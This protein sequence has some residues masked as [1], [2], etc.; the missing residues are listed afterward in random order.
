MPDY[1][2]WV[3][4]EVPPARDA[5]ND[6]NATLSPRELAKQL[7]IERLAYAGPIERLTL[8]HPQGLTG[9]YCR[10]LMNHDHVPWATHGSKG[11]PLKEFRQL[12]DPA[13]EQGRLLALMTP[14]YTAR[15]FTADAGTAESLFLDIVVCNKGNS[16]C[17]FEG[18]YPNERQVRQA[19]P[20]GQ[21]NY[22][23]G[24]CGKE[25]RVRSE[26]PEGTIC[27]YKGPRTQERLVRK[28]RAD[29][30]IE[31][32]RIN[33]QDVAVRHVT[34]DG[35]TITT[36]RLDGKHHGGRTAYIAKVQSGVREVYEGEQNKERLVMRYERDPL[37]NIQTYKGSGNYERLV[38]KDWL[39][40]DADLSCFEP[41][42]LKVSAPPPFLVRRDFFE[43]PRRSERLV[44]LEDWEEGVVTVE[45]HY[46]GSHL[47]P[48]LVFRFNPQT[49][50]AAY[51]TGKHGEEV[52]YKSEDREGNVFFYGPDG[53]VIDTEPA[54]VGPHAKKRNKHKPKRASARATA[55]AEAARRAAVRKRWRSAAWRAL[56]QHRA[57]AEAT[58]ANAEAAARQA[59][60][61]EQADAAEKDASR[62]AAAEAKAARRAAIAR[63]MR[64]YLERARLLRVA[65]AIGGS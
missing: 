23:K 22:Y 4:V 43:G 62:A 20:N 26:H 46:K 7:P 40:K 21:I 54:P 61:R 12:T 18:P 5:S 19:H 56:R 31:Y 59:A 55:D 51:F 24:E 15:Y 32:A 65:E 27:H 33:G 1:T 30:T 57:D 38:R 6:A 58:R 53:T 49:N 11:L 14:N 34:A 36:F 35:D 52:L 39:W 48:R 42:V 10:W 13:F 29:C 17:F 3:P 44:K 37:P 9:V 41:H 25:H 2:E 63:S 8:L 28:V 50:E 64:E 60:V 47:E 45:E 16:V